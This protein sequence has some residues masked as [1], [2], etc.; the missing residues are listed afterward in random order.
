MRNAIITYAE[1]N[2]FVQT[3]DS[4]IFLH[5]L[6]KHKN[7]DKIVFTRGLTDENLHML[8]VYF[9]KVI[10]CSN[11]I[12]NNAR[13]R[14]MAYYNWM[15]EHFDKYE[16]V[17]HLDFRDI[18]IQKDPFEFMQSH[19]DKDVFV[20]SEG[21]KIKDNKW[22]TMDMAYYHTH[23]QFHKDDF[24]DYYVING[25]TIGGKIFPLSQ[26][27]LLLWTNSNRLSR[28]NTDQATLNYLYP[29]FKMNPKIMV[30][31]PYE[32]TFCAT[33]EGIKY[34]NVLVK[35]DGTEVCNQSDEKYSIFHQW[36]RTEIAEKIRDKQARTLCFSIS[37]L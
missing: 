5:N 13:D 30:C 25:G 20:C 16:Y 15:V 31:H 21:M 32:D 2:D 18:V 35:Y 29:Y 7:F 28:S 26:L 17:M 24:S 3:L 36:D 34:G 22:N 9:D 8:S 27:F 14:F 6:K 10:V 19:S 37:T 1:G 23:L 12:H 11:P 4:E 33:G